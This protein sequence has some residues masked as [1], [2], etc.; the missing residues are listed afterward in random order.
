MQLSKKFLFTC[1]QRADWSCLP[2]TCPHPPE[3]SIRKEPVTQ[4]C[5]ST[6]LH[7]LF[8]CLLF[9]PL[10]NSV[11]FAPYSD[12]TNKNTTSGKRLVHRQTSSS[13]DQ[14]DQTVPFQVLLILVH[15]F[16]HIISHF[17]LLNSWQQHHRSVN[18]KITMPPAISWLIPTH[19]HIWVKDGEVKLK[20]KPR[21]LFFDLW[22]ISFIHIICSAGYI[23][24]RRPCLKTAPED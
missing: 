2:V 13:E 17:L 15:N 10:P 19:N 7:V 22:L 20:A 6:I 24:C 11:P 12:Q 8:Y 16:H 18:S 9:K 23:S 5:F 1:E 14:T 3:G 4:G 21:R